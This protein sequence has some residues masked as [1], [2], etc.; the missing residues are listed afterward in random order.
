MAPATLVPVK[1]TGP[2]KVSPLSQTAVSVYVPLRAPRPLTDA[3]VDHC[4]GD[5]IVMPPWALKNDAAAVTPTT[6]FGV[7][8]GMLAT[9][10]PP[11]TSVPP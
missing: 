1:V 9:M 2:L 6:F 10:R 11:A 8:C 4:C 5:T 3:N 7:A